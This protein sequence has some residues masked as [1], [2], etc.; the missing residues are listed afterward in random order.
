MIGDKVQLDCPTLLNNIRHQGPLVGYVKDVFD[1]LNSDGSEGNLEIDI[2]FGYT[3]WIRYK[4]KKDGGTLH[5]LE[6][7][8]NG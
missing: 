6:R 1:A 3:G 8:T 7:K 5:V 4:P 2:Q